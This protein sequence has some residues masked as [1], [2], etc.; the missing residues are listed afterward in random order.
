MNARDR[1]PVNPRTNLAEQR[2][3]LAPR[4][5]EAGKNEKLVQPQCRPL[6][7]SAP[8]AANAGL[9]GRSSRATTRRPRQRQ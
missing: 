3:C 2:L 5:D 6:R 9:S 7:L 8:R 1:P 4:F